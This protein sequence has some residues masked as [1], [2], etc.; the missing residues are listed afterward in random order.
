MLLCDSFQESCCYQGSGGLFQF[1]AR[2]SRAFNNFLPCW[3]HTSTCASSS[4]CQFCQLIWRSCSNPVYIDHQSRRRGTYAGVSQWPLW[5]NHSLTRS[6]LEKVQINEECLLH[7][8]ESSDSLSLADTSDVVLGRFLVADAA[9]RGL[10][11]ILLLPGIMLPVPVQ[12]KNEQS[13]QQILTCWK[14]TSTCA[15]SMSCQSCQLML[16]TCSK[17]VHLDHQSRRRGT[18]AGVKQW[19]LWENHSLHSFHVRKGSDQ[20][21]LSP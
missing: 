16:H 19:P 2:M 1:K 13:I 3:K 6:I 4:P 7:N 20:W 5:E 10:P 21:R 17:A 18:H 11:G 14:H 8:V 9:V 12:S 15:S